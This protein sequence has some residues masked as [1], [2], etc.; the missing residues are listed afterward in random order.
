MM[1]SI[2]GAWPSIAEPSG[3]KSK[4]VISDRACELYHK[5]CRLHATKH[6]GVTTTVGYV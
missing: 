2:V 6:V 5:H 4:G 1:C 3:L